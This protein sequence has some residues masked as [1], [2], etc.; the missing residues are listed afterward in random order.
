MLDRGT[1]VIVRPLSGFKEHPVQTAIVH[2]EHPGRDAVTVEQR[3]DTA[4]LG[5]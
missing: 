3:P 2:W 1:V 5:R 4:V